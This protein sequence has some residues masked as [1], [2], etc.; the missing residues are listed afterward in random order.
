[1]CRKK[2]NVGP[3]PLGMVENLSNSIKPLIVVD[4]SMASEWNGIFSCGT[5]KITERYFVVVKNME[6][7]LDNPQIIELC[8]SKWTF[9]LSSQGVQK[10]TCLPYWN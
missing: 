7:Q 2:K 9:N 5:Q 4:F 10:T 1:M 3:S 6:S 8:F